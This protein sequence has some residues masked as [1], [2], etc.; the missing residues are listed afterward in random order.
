[1]TRP[2]FENRESE[3]KAASV[4]AE[5]SQDIIAIVSYR[6]YLIYEGA[7]AYTSRSGDDHVPRVTVAC[8]EH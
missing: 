2:A 1:M 5:L 7:F 4:Y 8:I 3:A 6:V